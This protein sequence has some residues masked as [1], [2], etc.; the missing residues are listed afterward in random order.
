MKQSV[1]WFDV[2]VIL[3]DDHET[4]LVV[5]DDGEVWFGYCETSYSGKTYWRAVHTD[6]IISVFHW[7]HLPEPPKKGEDDE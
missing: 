6:G 1:E 2:D 4:V 7:A 5:M 3:P